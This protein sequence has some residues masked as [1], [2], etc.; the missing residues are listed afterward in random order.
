VTPLR[1][2]LVIDG[3]TGDESSVEHMRSP[4]AQPRGRRLV[5]CFHVLLLDVCLKLSGVVT[6]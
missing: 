5:F 4:G 1:L 6:K 2:Q 3:G